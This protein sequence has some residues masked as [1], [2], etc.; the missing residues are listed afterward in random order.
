[1]T[2]ET[3]PST[4]PAIAIPCPESA[5]DDDLILLSAT[6]PNTIAAIEPT[7]GTQK[8][9]IPTTRLTIAHGHVF[10]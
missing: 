1:M 6:I 5:P 9:A 2:N 8:L 3:Q 4:I 7:T 10:G